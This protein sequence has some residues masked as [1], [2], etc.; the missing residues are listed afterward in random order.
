MGVIDTGVVAW[1]IGAGCATG[2]SCSVS[3]GVDVD[4]SDEVGMGGFVGLG[5][6]LL[7]GACWICVL[8]LWVL[9]PLYM[10]W[11]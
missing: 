4:D 7:S 8:W 2:G 6:L 5:T 11:Q 10:T 9:P 3:W 1:G